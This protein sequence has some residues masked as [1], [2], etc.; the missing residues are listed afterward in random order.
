[1]YKSILIAIAV[2]AAG[3]VPGW[4]Q[5]V[6]GGAL[7]A[8]SDI[9]PVSLDPIFGNAPSVDGNY[10][11]LF[12]DNLFYVDANG[13]M[14]PEL[15]TS[16]SIAED[17]SSMTLQLRE[18]V[19]FHDGT[20]FDAAAVEYSIERVIDPEVNAPHGTDIS[21][22][23]SVDV[24]SDYEVRI[25]FSGFN[26]AVLPGLANEAGMIVSPTAAEAEGF[27]R[28]PVGTGPFKFVE[29]RSGDRVVGERNP[30]YW[31][32]DVDGNALPYL[33]KVSIRVIPNT[34]VK[35]LEA[36]SG[37][38]QLVDTVQVQDFPAIEEADGI[39]L[40]EKP[41]G[42]H[43]F[44]AFNTSK[45]PFDNVDLR[46]AVL[47]AVNNAAIEQVVSKGYG[48]LTPTLVP[49]SEFI[50]DGDLKATEFDVE[51]ATSLREE[52][53]FDETITISVIQRD[54]DTQIAQIVQAMLGQAGFDVEVEILE[55]GA[56][57]D[58]VRAANHEI[59]LLRINVPRIDPSLVFTSLMGRDA[60]LNFAAY[61]NEEF[62][63]LVDA[64]QNTID[65][66]QR[67]S[68]YIDVQKHLLD[69]AVYGFMFLRPIRDVAAEN[70][71]GLF[72]ES[73]GTWRLEEAFFT[74]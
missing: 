4:A 45:P 49:P 29:W 57:V 35:I 16:W 42:I 26:G 72:R 53:G 30:D 64:A 9:E 5:S 51:A 1:M 22:V 19:V 36:R 56:W 61:S 59:G 63:D 6:A 2:A 21:A 54:P 28:N 65:R 37:E 73:S 25:N 67:K 14:Q 33:D 11:N 70:L 58:K 40:I 20:H 15:A 17:G 48:A 31:R 13:E 34:A 69:H 44:M 10:Y 7:V 68:L 38:V 32:T 43:Q 47:H 74:N 46:R 24:L 71:E 66:D 50:F 39:E 27:A 41:T 8:A 3:T 12:Y 55:R 62:F 23:T 18:G 60:G 52:L